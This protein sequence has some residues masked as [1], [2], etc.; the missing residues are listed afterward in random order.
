M[1]ELTDNNFKT[2]LL[3]ISENGIISKMV[4]LNEMMLF[5]LRIPASEIQQFYFSEPIHFG[6]NSKLLDSNLESLK[7]EDVLAL[8]IYRSRSEH[9]PEYLCVSYHHKSGG[10]RDITKIAV[11]PV[12]A[13]EIDSP[14]EGY[15]AGVT[16]RAT[17]FPKMLKELK[18]INK[19][20]VL[21]TSI[22]G[23][24]IFGATME[25]VVERAIVFSADA[26]EEAVCETATDSLSLA[27]VF[28]ARIL[29]NISK[30]SSFGNITVFFAPQLPLKLC[31]PMGAAGMITIYVLT[32]RAH[33]EQNQ[34]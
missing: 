9:L 5:E 25:G 18:T 2:L 26:S 16:V 34:A 11:Q 29:A 32:N 19:T 10:Y 30:I 13:V 1:V 20:E 22:P 17:K 8:K 3:S 23:A 21:I 27:E 14:L 15:P 33:E 12:Q 31:V 4:T 28:D 6:V 24:V 7:K